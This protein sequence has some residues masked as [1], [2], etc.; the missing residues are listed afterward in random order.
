MRRLRLGRLAGNRGGMVII[1]VLWVLVLL[2]FLSLSLGQSTRIEFALANNFIGKIKSKYLAWGGVQYAL[3]L[4]EEDTAD[5][6]SAKFD[7]LTWC[8]VRPV[9]DKTSEDLFQRHELGDGYFEI[10]YWHR[11]ADGAKPVHAYGMADEERRINLNTVTKNNFLILSTLIQELGYEEEVA[12][13]VT[14]GVIDWR[15]PDDVLNDS[16]YGA[17][18]EYYQGLEKPYRP[19]NM[20]FE[21][22]EELL[23]IRGVTPELFADLKP[24]VTLFPP[25]GELRINFNTAPEIMLRSLAIAVSGR[26]SGTDENDAESLVRKMLDYRRGDDRIENTGDD[27]IIEADGLMLNRREQALFIRM[28]NLHR[29]RKAN[30]VRVFVTGVDQNRMVTSTIEA[31]IGRDNLDMVYW[32]R[33]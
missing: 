29:T 21:S 15:D 14:H 19:K 27:R 11:Q 18:L 12:L 25:G 6:E 16:E 3:H 26:A 30:F 22:L 4:I 31:V 7:S 5:E 24:Y 2:S 33:N 28:S 13:T 20:Q 10:G 9:A 17:E 32:K 23:L 1:T 8:A